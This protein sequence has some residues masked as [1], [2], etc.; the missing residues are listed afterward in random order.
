MQSDR[1]AILT[2]VAV[3]RITPAEA[4]RLLLACNESAWS[5]GRE[6]LWILAV[7][8]TAVCLTQLDP[9]AWLLAVTEVIHSLLL[10]VIHQVL[11]A[12]A[13]FFAIHLIGG[14]L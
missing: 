6:P 7:C 14:I 4:E 11:P 9:N 3:G 8:I 5:S 1:R 12:I 2:L 10:V 13:H